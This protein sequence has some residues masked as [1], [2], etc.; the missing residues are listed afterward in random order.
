VQSPYRAVVARAH[1]LL[2]CAAAM[3]LW[4]MCSSAMAQ[5]SGWGSLR[6]ISTS[7]PG[8][9]RKD[10]SATVCSLGNHSWIVVYQRDTTASSQLVY[11]RSTN[12]GAT[13][14]SATVLYSGQV[15]NEQFYPSVD[16]N[17]SGMAGVA[18][19]KQYEDATATGVL[20]VS[21]SPNRGISWGS[22]RFVYELPPPGSGYHFRGRPHIR[23][24]LE[25][26][27]A[28]AQTY[29]VVEMWP[30]PY[31]WFDTSHSFWC[32]SHDNGFSW[33]ATS[34][35]NPWVYGAQPVIQPPDHYETIG[36]LMTSGTTQWI[37]GMAWEEERNSWPFTRSFGFSIKT[38]GG[39]FWP[40]P[41]CTF[42]EGTIVLARR[43]NDELGA[44]FL[45]NGGVCS[46]ISSGGVTAWSEKT[47]LF[48]P[49]QYATNLL[50]SDGNSRLIAVS[51]DG[52]QL[53]TY[54][55]SDGGLTWQ[56][57]APAAITL[58]P[59]AVACDASGNWMCIFVRATSSTTTDLVV[60]MYRPQSNAAVADWSVYR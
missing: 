25:Q 57:R 23:A 8:L 2:T 38:S 1:A 18:W 31:D 40:P 36:S 4:A 35:L 28:V 54:Q 39:S 53:L 34:E 17:A 10:G 19:L 55:S 59:G 20:Y 27:W 22:K 48:T 16:V 33:T 24:G 32:F 12:D 26:E 45:C 44:L 42:E 41:R 37:L 14:T 60:A 56:N 3:L 15:G 9:T 51:A 50:E 43:P 13:W 52:T 6:L 11:S 49:S 46:S 47:V 21:H 30:P 5:T 29:L 7:P 58:A